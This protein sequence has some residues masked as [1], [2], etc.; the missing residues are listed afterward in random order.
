MHLYGQDQQ[1]NESVDSSAEVHEA[2]S[3]M[4]GLIGPSFD[5]AFKSA[6]TLALAEDMDSLSIEKFG[7][8]GMSLADIEAFFDPTT[9]T[10]TETVVCMASGKANWQS[11]GF[12]YGWTGNSD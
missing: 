1:V 3:A 2:F 6:F 9:Q 8:Q 4:Y 5:D 10:K 11:M 12:Q 7:A